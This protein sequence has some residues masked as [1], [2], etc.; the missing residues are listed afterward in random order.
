MNTLT[1]IHTFGNY[2]LYVHTY[3]CK[4]TRIYTH[5]RA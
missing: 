2:A 3:M 5:K 1:I 4:R